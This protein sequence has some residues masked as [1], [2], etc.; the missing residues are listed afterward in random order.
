MRNNMKY[1]DEFVSNT[2]A[3]SSSQSFFDGDTKNVMTGKVFYKIFVG[4]TYDYSLLFTNI[5]D[6]TFS[7]GSHSHRNMICDEWEIESAAVCITKSANADAEGKMIQITFEGKKSKM[8]MPGEF[9]STDPVSLTA[10]KGDYLCLEINFK[11]KMVPCHWEIIVP[12]FRKKDGIW[13][14]AKEVPVP[15]MI[16]VK[17]TPSLK[18]GFLGDSITQGIGTEM[19]S[20]THW[21]ARLAE[22]CGEENSYWNMGIGFGRADDA[23]TDGAWLFKAKQMDAI[24]VCFGVN[25][26]FRGFDAEKV[27]EN[28]QTIV[29]RLG[30]ASCR[31]LVQ[32]IPPFDFDEEQEKIRREVNKFILTELDADETFDVD[33]VL[34]D[35]SRAVYGGHPDAEGCEKWAS[36]LYPVFKQFISGK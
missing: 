23:A 10:D 7:D 15:S 11:G 5:T 25:D 9:F 21:N 32:T 19:D 27:K 14:P 4:G 34:A 29:K 18:V 20:Y 17:R 1:F 13:E 6:S 3:G 2:L 8:V 28:L 22:M 35:G 12:T 31:V 30:S 33:P 24:T 26:I 36:A 16:G